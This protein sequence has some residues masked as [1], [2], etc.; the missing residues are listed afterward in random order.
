MKRPYVIVNC[1][2]SADGKI[3]SPARKQIRISG[4]EDIERMYNLRSDCDAVLVGIETI[5]ADDPKLTV[6][7]KYVH[8]PKQPLRVILDSY[9]RTPSHALV[10]NDIS[11]TLII[12]KK[13][14]Q[15]QFP[16]SNVEIVECELDKDGYLDVHHILDILHRK[17]IKKLLV[18]GG[19][20]V[21]WTFLQNNVVDDLFIFIGPCIIGGKDTPTVADGKGIEGTTGIALKIVSVQRL[22]LGVLIHYQLDVGGQ[23]T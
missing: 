18:E 14:K 1:A 2:M 8:H 20:T 15:K 7:E 13:G 16:Q 4:E 23:F 12:T 5:L 6:N 3:A 22:G 19:G 10:L 9:A 11:T 17:G 21:I